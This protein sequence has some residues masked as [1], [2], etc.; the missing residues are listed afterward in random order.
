MCL[1]DVLEELLQD[2]VHDEVD[3]K[4]RDR[5]ALTLT[6]WASSRFHKLRRNN[7]EQGNS[8][9]DS[10]EHGPNCCVD[11]EQGHISERSPLLKDGKS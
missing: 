10:I 1:L 6:R 3:V 9:K 5:A 7:E 11:I 8:A 2:S 4:D